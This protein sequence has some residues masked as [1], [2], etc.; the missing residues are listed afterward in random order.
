MILLLMG[1]AKLSNYKL[2]CDL[3]NYLQ[4]HKIFS[5]DQCDEVMREKYHYQQLCIPAAIRMDTF[6]TTAFPTKG[7]TIH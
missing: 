3:L 7:Y 4:A 6:F 2:P 1:S 5:Q